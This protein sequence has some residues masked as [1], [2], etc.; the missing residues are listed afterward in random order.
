MNARRSSVSKN[1]SSSQQ[2]FSRDE[3]S[4][5]LGATI[6]GVWRGAGAVYPVQVP[7][8]PSLRGAWEKVL[9]PGWS[10]SWT[11]L[12]KHEVLDSHYHPVVSYVAIVKGRAQLIG[13]QSGF[14]DAGSVVRIPAWNLHGF[15]TVAGQDPFWALTWQPLKNSLFTGSEP[16]VLYPGDEGAPAEPDARIRADIVQAR[17]RPFGDKS[18]PGS[19]EFEF[20]DLSVEKQVQL[21]VAGRAVMFLVSG[22]ASVETATSVYEMKEGDMLPL[23]SETVSCR[24]SE[25]LTALALLRF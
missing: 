5:L 3:I 17:V 11:T 14:V 7:E 19:P 25:A 15:K 13:Q 20:F 22:S 8:N 18:L 1:E 23:V 12:P 21:Q 10:V 6:N 9:L 24:G 4:P 2:L 16:N